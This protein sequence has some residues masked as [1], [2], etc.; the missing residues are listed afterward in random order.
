MRERKRRERGR[1]GVTKRE[2]RDER[3]R[4]ARREDGE[5]TGGREERGR[6]ERGREGKA[7]RR[8][9][10]TCERAVCVCTHVA[11][12]KSISPHLWWLVRAR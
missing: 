4:R 5:K 9:R 1:G 3:E 11:W 12:P 10:N 2:R 6:E 7:K 8:I